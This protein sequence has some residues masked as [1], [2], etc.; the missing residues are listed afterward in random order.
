MSDTEKGNA[1]K[2]NGDERDGDKK[3]VDSESS[4]GW[5][6]EGRTSNTEST[7]R[8]CVSD[9]KKKKLLSKKERDVNHTIAIKADE[10]IAGPSCERSNGDVSPSSVDDCKTSTPVKVKK[11]KVKATKKAL[12]SKQG[13]F[14]RRRKTQIA[15]KNLQISSRS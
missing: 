10:P 5:S 14:V 9:R 12:K 2:G 15:E 6:E 1:G 3:K 8:K 7:D 4:L 13:V 11:M